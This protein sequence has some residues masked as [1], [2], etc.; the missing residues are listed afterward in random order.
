M[1]NFQLQLQERGIRIQN[2]QVAEAK[3]FFLQLYPKDWAKATDPDEMALDMKH[4][5][6]DL[7]LPS[8]MSCKDIDLIQIGRTIAHSGKKYIE[9][10]QFE[11]LS[12]QDV[13]VKSQSIDIE[14]KIECMKKI[15]NIKHCSPM[16]NYRMLREIF[17]LALL[18]HSSLIQILGYCIRGDRISASLH[19]KGLV[20]ITEV[21]TPL[22]DEVIKMLPWHSRVMVSF[23]V[24]LDNRVD[25]N[26]LN[27]FIF[28]E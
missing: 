26:T 13:T 28:N 27:E 12:K 9:R 6:L 15:Y 18:K 21:G 23:M 4:F 11:N 3:R 7:G 16:G 14:T 8:N 10:G 25:L 5:L 19:K 20:L 2:E 17:L 1:H 24:Y 22:T